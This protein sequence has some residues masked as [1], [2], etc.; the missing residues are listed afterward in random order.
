MITFLTC[1][2]TF[3]QLAEEMTTKKISDG[4]EK[5]KEAITSYYL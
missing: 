5:R 4:I 3:V 1:K 2:C